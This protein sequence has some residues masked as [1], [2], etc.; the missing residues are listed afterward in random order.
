MVSCKNGGKKEPVRPPH[1]SDNWVTGNKESE[2]KHA[3]SRNYD[4]CLE[5]GRM[6][7]LQLY[8]LGI[9]N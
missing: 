8:I 4:C 9:H 6:F 7:Y 2:G 3:M 5:F 1:I